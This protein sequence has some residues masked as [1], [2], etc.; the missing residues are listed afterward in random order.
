MK[1]NRVG[2]PVDLVL[3]GPRRQNWR[4]TGF[5]I[6]LTLPAA[7]AQ[8]ELT[9]ALLLEAV[10]PGSS[11]SGSVARRKVSGASRRHAIRFIAEFND[12]CLLVTDASPNASS[13]GGDAEGET[14]AEAAVDVAA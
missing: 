7:F 3:P 9:R 8:S 13:L 4:K 12:C 2:C 5:R 10:P 11:R 14:A 1:D 6:S